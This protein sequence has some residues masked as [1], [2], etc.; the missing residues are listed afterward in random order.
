LALAVVP[1]AWGA[2]NARM[3][4]DCAEDGTLDGSYPNRDLRRAANNLPADLDEY[5]DCRELIAAAITAGPGRKQ[6]RGGD[7][8]GGGGA[9]GGS[10]GGWRGGR[11][12]P[13]R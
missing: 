5:S 2:S 9:G 12:G 8:D 6:G 1:A 13:D 3:I 10:G 4:Q 11:R 7:D